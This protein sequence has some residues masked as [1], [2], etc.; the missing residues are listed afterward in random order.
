MHH[1]QR[2]CSCS[3]TWPRH[4]SQPTPWENLSTSHKILG[5]F[6]ALWSKVQNRRKKSQFCSLLSAL[7]QRKHWL[8]FGNFDWFISFSHPER[9]CWKF[10][11]VPG[12]SILF[13]LSCC[14]ASHFFLRLCLV[15]TQNF[16]LPLFYLFFFF[17]FSTPSVWPGPERISWVAS[18]NGPTV[19]LHCQTGLTELLSDIED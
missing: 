9:F 17:F 12:F 8:P 15:F 14:R 4:I 18:P 7:N 1:L 5:A 16:P 11:A 3:H 6:A 13:D 2:Q 10:P 19:F